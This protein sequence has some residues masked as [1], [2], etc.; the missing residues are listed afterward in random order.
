MTRKLLHK[1]KE[2]MGERKFGISSTLH[3]VLGNRLAGCL[4]WLIFP[5]F[6]TGSQKNK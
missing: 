6:S 2:A 1:N 5:D 3:K 4:M